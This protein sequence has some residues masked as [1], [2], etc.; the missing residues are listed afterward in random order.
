MYL[1]VASP[2][3]TV[4]IGHYSKPC[5]Y[6]DTWLSKLSTWRLILVLTPYTLVITCILA[7]FAA[8]LIVYVP[9]HTGTSP[10][11]YDVGRL[12]SP[13][14]SIKPAHDLTFLS[15]FSPGIQQYVDRS[16]TSALNK[17]LLCVK[18]SMERVP[19]ML[20]D[21]VTALTLTLV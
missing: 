7:L 12:P 15:C 8:A 4:F 20:T 21:H 19:R 17:R 1:D 14:S 9:S 13:S 11:Q 6:S 18:F 5:P 10:K 3:L 2:L 16:F